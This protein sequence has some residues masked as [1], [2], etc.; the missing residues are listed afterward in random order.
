MITDRLLHAHVFRTGGFLFR[1]VL[2]KVPGL[3]I[4]KDTLHPSVD[5]MNRICQENSLPPPP[6]VAFVRNPWEWYVS[7]WC[8]VGQVLPG[9]QCS[10]R[11]Y[12]EAIRE[13]STIDANITTM[14]HHYYSYIQAHRANYVG[15]FE[16]LREDIIRILAEIMPDLVSR[17]SL[18]EIM[19]SEPNYHPSIVWTTGKRMVHYSRYYGPQ[20]KYWVEKWDAGLIAQFGYQFESE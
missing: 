7:Q 15:R 9:Y 5:V 19:N 1:G 14:T 18:I 8:W 2:K 20:M 4:I 12:M 16:N 13:A 6:I 3:H 17:E 11:S 10:F